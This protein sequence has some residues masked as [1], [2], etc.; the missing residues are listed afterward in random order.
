MVKGKF[1]KIMTFSMIK[2]ITQL[3]KDNQFKI[4]FESI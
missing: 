2:R 1:S 4:T 3:S